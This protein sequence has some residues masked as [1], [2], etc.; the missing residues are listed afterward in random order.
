MGAH[1]PLSV[2]YPDWEGGLSRLQQRTGMTRALAEVAYLRHKGF[3]EEATARRLGISYSAL[4]GRVRRLYEHFRLN[5]Q[6]GLVLFVER[7][8][9]N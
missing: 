2:D 6:T 9:N 4:R 3:S 7:T 1:G 5:S 8:L